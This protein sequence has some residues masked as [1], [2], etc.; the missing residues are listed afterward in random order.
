[1]NKYK[2]LYLFWLLPCYLLFLSGH[3]ALVFYSIV[4][5]YENGQSYYADV[6]EYDLKQIAAQTNGYLI[7]EFEKDN[8]QSHR[9][10]LSLPVEMAGPVGKTKVIPIR[11]QEDAFVNIV[12]IPTYSTQKGLVLTNLAMA[13][14]GF[15]I[16]LFTAWLVHRYVRKKT[17]GKDEQLVIERVDDEQ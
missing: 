12:M 15:L 3:Q 16:A 1:M 7:L 14:V 4:D 5:T 13:F 8:S 10:K 2:L 17:T 9:Q 6:V 11:Y